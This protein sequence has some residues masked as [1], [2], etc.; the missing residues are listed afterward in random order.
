MIRITPHP[1]DR[2]FLLLKVPQDLNDAIGS[3]AP[4]QLA[5]DLRGYVMEA[6]KLGSLKNWARFHKIPLLDETKAP[7][8]PTQP[9][10]CG[11]VIETWTAKDGTEVRETCCAPYQAGNIPTYCGACGQPANPVIFANNGP[12]VGVKCSCGHVNHGGPAYCV[13]CGAV[14]PERHLSAPAIARVK[15][16]PRP[17][18]DAIDE[19]RK[20]LAP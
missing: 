3:F 18:G 4:A 12:D 20:E 5:V 17:L 7:G 2:D 16:E 6:D 19:L 8:E 13:R 10:Q 9:V 11:N 14:L 1:K 15:G